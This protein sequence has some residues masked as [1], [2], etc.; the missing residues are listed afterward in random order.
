[1]TI[2]IHMDSFWIG[3]IAGGVALSMI[4]SFFH[5]FLSRPPEERAKLFRKVD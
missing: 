5:W 1:M 2:T 4:L 3:F